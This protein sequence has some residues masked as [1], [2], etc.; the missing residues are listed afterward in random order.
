MFLISLRVQIRRTD[1]INLE[2]AYHGIDEYMY[3]VELYYKKLALNQ[4]VERKL[5]F[6]ATDDPTVLPQ[7]RDK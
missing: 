4:N 7:A 5:V 3:W 2:A 1:K 6:I